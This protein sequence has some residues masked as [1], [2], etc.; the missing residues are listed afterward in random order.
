MRY[1][2]SGD[3][4]VRIILK[5]NDSLNYY[6]D[7][8]AS[9]FAVKTA[10]LMSLGS[11][12]E[13]AL[14]EIIFPFGYENVRAGYNEVNIIPAS[15]AGDEITIDEITEMPTMSFKVNP[16]FYTPTSL[17]EQINANMSKE[18]MELRQREEVNNRRSIS[19]LKRLRMKFGFDVAKILGFNAYEWLT[20]GPEKKIGLNQAGPYRNISLLNVYCDAVEESLVG[21]HQHQLLRIVNWPYT[22]QNGFTFNPSLIYDHPYFMRVKSTN[23][24]TIGITITDSFNIPITFLGNEPVVVTLE[25]RKI[26]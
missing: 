17:I 9:N 19:T 13:V 7:N 6:P 14:T 3:I 10:H 1:S 25:F 5:S 24:D 16:N 18:L 22:V 23:R 26:Q 4:M 21:Q 8:N 11:D 2:Q 12:L 20:F 15:D